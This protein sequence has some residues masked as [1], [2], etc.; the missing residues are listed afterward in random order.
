MADQLWRVPLPR[1]AESPFEVFVNGVPQT[2]G[3]D[4]TVAGRELLFTQELSKEGHLGFWRW[5]A[6]FLA[7]FGT[8]RKNDS[9][10]LKY[11]LNG[12]VTLATGLDILAP[13]GRPSLT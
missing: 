5:T 2:E 3:S 12:R 8:Y 4:Y 1:G 7:L 9:V 6:I 11:R 13:D 10:D